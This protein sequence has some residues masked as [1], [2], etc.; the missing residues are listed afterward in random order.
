MEEWRLDLV[1]GLVPNLTLY[2]QRDYRRF[3]SAHLQYLQGLC[4]LSQQAANNSINEF[5]TSLLVTTELLSEASFQDR[6]NTLIEQSKYNAPILLSRFLFTVQSIF[7]GNAFLSTYGTNYLYLTKYKP[8]WSSYSPTEA[9]IY[10]A[11]CSCGI[12]SNCTTQATFIETNSS[13]S[14]NISIKG[15]KMGCTPSESFF[16]ST[17]ECFYDQSCLD[18][19]QKYTKYPHSLTPLSTTKNPS[20]FS[21]NTTISELVTNLFIERWSPQINYPSY[22]EQ[23]SPSVCSY[24][25]VEK[26]NILYIITV[27]LGIQGGLTIVLKWLCPKLVR[28]GSKIYRHRKKRM[29]PVHPGVRIETPSTVPIN[30]TI[31]HTTWNHETRSM[32]KRLQ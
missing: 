2:G 4:R 25:R 13:T 10:D 29:A 17:L 15:M 6:L 28:I 1:N 32:N 30:T 21:R 3:I 22:Y 9:I 18:L 14:T 20:R 19:I 31:Q 7:H 8:N 5:L 11:E 16:L 26:F 27:I 12:Y 24:T 23:C